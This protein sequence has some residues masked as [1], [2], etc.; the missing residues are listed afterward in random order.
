MRRVAVHNIII[1]P[2]E[3]RRGAGVM[4]DGGEAST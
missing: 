3:R 1:D 2:P 4:H